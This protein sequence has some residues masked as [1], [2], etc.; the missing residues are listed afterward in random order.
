M[1]KLIFVLICLTFISCKKENEKPQ[2]E[3]EKYNIIVD[4]ADEINSKSMSGSYSGMI[5][6][7]DC[8][9]IAVLMTLK[10]D[11]TYSLETLYLGKE[12]NQKENQKGTYKIKSDLLIL[13]ISD[14]PNQY[15]IG[16]NYLLQL[17][18]EGQEITGETAKM[19]K[20]VKN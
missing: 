5:P 7:A 4:Q 1:K 14:A 11:K 3:E 16:E 18:M 10:D 12:K 19:Y 13:D 15:R 2:T 9:G 8:E 17:D 20:L 6:C